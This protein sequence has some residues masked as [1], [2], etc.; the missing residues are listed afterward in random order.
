MTVTSFLSTLLWVPSLTC[1][2]CSRHRKLPALLS[3][4]TGT[5]GSWWAATVA[6]IGGSRTQVLNN[7]YLMEEVSQRLLMKRSALPD[8]IFTGAV[9]PAW[10]RLWSVYCPSHLPVRI[11]PAVWGS[12][13]WVCSRWHGR[14]L[15][16]LPHW[17]PPLSAS[18][19]WNGSP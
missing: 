5:P 13:T 3:W 1:A 10:G 2:D 11:C 6:V 14:L 4:W 8:N 18:V 17:S 15:K 16:T 9:K 7:F 12:Q 19:V